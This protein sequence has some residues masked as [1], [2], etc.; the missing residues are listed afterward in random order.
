[1]AIIAIIIILLLLWWLLQP[2]ITV[3]DSRWVNI[4]G[5][6]EGVMKLHEEQFRVISVS[7]DDCCEGEVKVEFEYMWEFY[8]DDWTPPDNRCNEPVEWIVKDSIGREVF[9]SESRTPADIFDDPY[10][11]TT[12]IWDCV[13]PWVV[14]VINGCL[15]PINYQWEL[16][17]WCYE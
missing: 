10:E 2:S 16:T 4:G 9:N 3:V 14:T 5:P 17:L 8:D 6:T 7:W 13:H 1:M 15:F 12:G 11:I